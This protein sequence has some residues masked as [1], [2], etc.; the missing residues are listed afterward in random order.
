MP[1]K[2]ILVHLADDAD[3]L[4][5]MDC[6][7][8]LAVRFGAHLT[9]LYITAPHA[10]AASVAGASRG[11]LAAMADAA[12]D[13]AATLERECHERCVARGVQME[14]H[15]EEGRGLG[16]HALFADLSVLSRVTGPGADVQA[17]T[18]LTAGGPVLMLPPGYTGAASGERPLVAWKNAQ[19]SARALHDA[20]P[21]LVEAEVTILLTVREEGGPDIP[22]VSAAGALNR[23]GVEVELRNQVGAVGDAGAVILAEAEGQACDMVVMGAYGRSRVREV[24][25]GDV[26]RHM[27]GQASLPLFLS[28]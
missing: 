19:E 15:M 22:G 3:H 17:G 25:F 6:A 23:H 26:T 27:F 21:F 1:Y 11:Y 8:G 2:T 13:H 7:I 5:R 14:W 16:R 10:E 20:L 24:V 12:R 4:A 28:H 9:A 18:A